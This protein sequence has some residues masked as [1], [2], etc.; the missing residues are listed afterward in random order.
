VPL[1]G[2]MAWRLSTKSAVSFLDVYPRA[3]AR[4]SR[5]ENWPSADLLP[6]S[7]RARWKLDTP[8]EPRLLEEPF[9]RVLAEHN[10]DQPPHVIRPV[11][12]QLREVRLQARDRVRRPDQ[13]V[14]R[15]RVG[16]PPLRQ[17][18]GPGLLAEGLEHGE[19]IHELPWI[20]PAGH[21]P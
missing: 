20:V 7:I 5:A 11:H 4:M 13:P 18:T 16:R 2:L 17:P 19:D 3:R 8:W 1:F 6:M 14:L 21:T 9:T 10:A 15:V 12:G